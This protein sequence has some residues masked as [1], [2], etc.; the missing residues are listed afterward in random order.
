[1]QQLR[2]DAVGA[3]APPQ[4]PPGFDGQHRHAAGPQD[5]KRAVT[6][7]VKLVIGKIRMPTFFVAAAGKAGQR[8]A[9]PAAH[10]AGSGG[11]IAAPPQLVT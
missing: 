6:P 2:Q 8:V 9:V 5:V 7:A 4:R 11:P 10:R 3:A 1:V